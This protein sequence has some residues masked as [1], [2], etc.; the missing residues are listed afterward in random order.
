MHHNGQSNVKV[1][2]NRKTKA[3]DLRGV[4]G[5]QPSIHYLQATTA[6]EVK[7]CPIQIVIKTLNKY[8]DS[9]L[10]NETQSMWVSWDRSRTVRLIFCWR[11]ESMGGG[12]SYISIRCSTTKASTT[13]QFSTISHNST[14]RCKRLDRKVQS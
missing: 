3:N 6:C 10:G 1:S 8:R 2:M 11:W 5:R 4:T 14:R 9:Q 13:A 12:C 7:D